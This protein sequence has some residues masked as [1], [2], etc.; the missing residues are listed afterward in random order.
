YHPVDSKLVR[1][2]SKIGAP[3][4]VLQRHGNRS[5]CGKTIEDAFGFFS[6]FRLQLDVHVVADADR[7]SHFLRSIGSHQDMT[8]Q[9]RQ[10]YMED[11]SFDMLIEL[12]LTGL[13]RDLVE[14]LDTSDKIGLKY[15]FVEVKSFFCIPWEV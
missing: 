7:E 12:R 1:K 2:A 15:T 5:P 3:K 4:H 11:H 8:A 6:R 10:L 13:A 9:D 14:S